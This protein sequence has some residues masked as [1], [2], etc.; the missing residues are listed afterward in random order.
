LLT[1]RADAMGRI[2][3]A[4]ACVILSFLPAVVTA[5]E[6][7]GT[8]R[9]LAEIRNELQRL[10]EQQ[11][12]DRMRIEELEQQVELLEKALSTEAGAQKT[13]EE[14]K[15]TAPA[16]HRL[17]AELRSLRP[18]GS[19]IFITGY[20][21]GQY[22]WRR[23]D[24]TSSFSAD[25][26]PIFVFRPVDW[27]L[28]DASL[29][30]T[31][32]E[33]SETEVDLEYGQVYIT[34]TDWLTLSAG[35][36]LIPFGEFIERIEPAWINKLVTV[37]LPFRKGNEGGLLPYSVIAAEV[38]GGLRLEYGRGTDFDY[39]LYIANSP[40]FDSTS[41]GMSSDQVGAPITFNNEDV[42]LGKAYGARVGL[43]PLPLE[44]EWGNLRVGASTFDGQWSGEDTNSATQ[45]AGVRTDLWFTSWGLDAAY[46]F[47]MG[48]VRGEY[49]STWRELPDGSH[50]KREGWY[51][52]AAYKLARLHRD[53]LNRI[54]LVTRYSAQ[55]Q[56]AAIQGLRPHPRQIALGIDYWLTT[57]VAWKVEYDCDF[58]RDAP[59]DDEV[60]TQIVVGF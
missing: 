12:R 36:S 3:S 15:K 55:N 27:I 24:D 59:D 41:D 10:R 26:S 28:F 7:A 18:G 37:P 60:W 40:H 31:L 1:D 43:R 35:K 6:E 58:P 53:Y 47:G 29:E 30:V 20:G 14:D 49:L 45:P 25:F 34:L 8:A 13:G 44:N 9:S 54:E 4:I 33:D 11:E 16:L 22:H 52:Q 21:L 5:Q 48:T 50:D 46:Q 2:R 42:N 32:P 57:T 39:T 56:R 23:T 19:R 38:R 17:Y 51:V